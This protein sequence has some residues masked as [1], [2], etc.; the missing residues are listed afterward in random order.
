MNPS[1]ERVVGERPPTATSTQSP[2]G[3]SPLLPHPQRDGG[4]RRLFH[5][6]EPIPEE[7]LP[8]PLH[9]GVPLQREQIPLEKRL[10]NLG[11]RELIGRHV[12][13]AREQACEFSRIRGAEEGALEPREAEFDQGSATPVS[14]F[15]EQPV[16]ERV[17]GGDIPGTEGRAPRGPAGGGEIPCHGG[18][19]EFLGAMM[20]EHQSLGAAGRLGAPFD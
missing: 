5:V 14:M 19:Q 16:P 11:H 15:L 4:P 6:A 13:R 20:M 17:E 18:E 8:D 2:L 9:G 7:R 3:A 1:A 10:E 12:E